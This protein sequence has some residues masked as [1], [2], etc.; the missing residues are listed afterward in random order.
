[1]KIGT[2][3]LA[4]NALYSFSMS[5]AKYKIAPN[6]SKTN[7]ICVPVL[8]TFECTYVEWFLMQ[9]ETTPEV[10]VFPFPRQQNL[11]YFHLSLPLKTS[12]KQKEKSFVLF[13]D[14]VTQVFSINKI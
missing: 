7:G 8:A 9:M 4:V 13:F 6:I 10:F 3:S 2:I 5:T 11:V 12:T 1:M 14:T